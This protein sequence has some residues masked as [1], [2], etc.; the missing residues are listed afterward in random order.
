MATQ[1]SLPTIGVSS[2][3]LLDILASSGP[4]ALASLVFSDPAEAE[5]FSSPRPG[6]SAAAPPKTPGGHPFRSPGCPGHAEM[7][8]LL[9]QPTCF[10]SMEAAMYEVQ[11]SRQLH[12]SARRAEDWGPWLA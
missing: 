4:Q 12:I 9:V 10:S 8:V 5:G 3:S 11:V 6:L 7:S 1:I 2:A